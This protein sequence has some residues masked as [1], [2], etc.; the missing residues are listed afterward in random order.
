[1]G[2]LLFLALHQLEDG[3]F[4]EFIS[5]FAITVVNRGNNTL[6]T[7]ASR[8]CCIVNYISCNITHTYR[9][10]IIKKTG[11]GLEL[12]TC[13]CYLLLPLC[14]WSRSRV[15][16]F[17][18]AFSFIPVRRGS[19][20][21]HNHSVCVVGSRLSV[22]RV[23][24]CFG[25]ADLHFTDFAFS[26]GKLPYFGGLIPFSLQGA[27]ASTWT[28]YSGFFWLRRDVIDDWQFLT[29]AFFLHSFD[30]IL[31]MLSIF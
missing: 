4:S 16:Q 15:S 7:S 1:M 12:V 18:L 25:S 20:G 2:N 8:Q 28:A 22:L 30:K 11:L 14:L 19:N 17:N 29:T 13:L 31:F 26:P 27:C 9:W 10:T 3:I 6:L 24:C 21:K 23:N 5:P